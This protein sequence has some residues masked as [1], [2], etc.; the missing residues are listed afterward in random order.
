MPMLTE[1]IEDYLEAIYNVQNKKGYVRVKDLANALSVSC[2]SVTEMLKKLTAMRLITYEKYGA[3]FLTEKGTQIARTVKDRHDTLVKLLVM[4]GVPGNIA[5][6]DAC[7]MEHHI[8]PV[9]L[10]HLKKYVETL[11]TKGKYSE[12]DAACIELG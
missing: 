5:D 3:V 6:K 7:E 1:R 12:R 11:E 2:P 8:S 9:S 4:A 10:E